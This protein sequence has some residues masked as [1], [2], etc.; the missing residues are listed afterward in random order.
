MDPEIS[1]REGEGGM[2]VDIQKFRKERGGMHC[3]P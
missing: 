1:K 2:E 3:I